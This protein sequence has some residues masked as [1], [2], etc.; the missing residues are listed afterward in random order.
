MV[1]IY[2]LKRE[3]QYPIPHDLSAQ[4]F[5]SAQNGGSQYCT[6]VPTVHHDEAMLASAKY[7]HP[8]HASFAET[9][10]SNV[11]A[12]SK[13]FKIQT[14]IRLSLTKGA[15]HTDN[16]EAL[17]IGFMN[18]HG[19][20]EDFDADDELTSVTVGDA[21][22]LT[23]ETSDRQT[24]P[25]YTTTKLSEKFSGSATLDAD[26]VG[27][28]TNQIL[29]Q[30]NFDIGLY[31]DML[32]YYTNSEKLKKVQNGLRWITL[33]RNNPTRVIKIRQ[34]VNTKASNPY[35]F[36]GN[37]IILPPSDTKYQIP[38]GADTTAINHVT[39]EVRTRFLEWNDNFHHE[40]A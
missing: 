1:G 13:I 17:R 2:R 6:I 35:M 12:E 21:L 7:S 5:L 18:I 10:A 27:L 29:E 38:V 19:A 25:I 34:S 3:K 16:I 40:R 22:E 9:D 39:V 33:T 24:Y 20:F 23:K 15:L 36:N 14:D 32:N 11:C 31:Y 30:V 37:L 8:E 28:T 26:E 4:F